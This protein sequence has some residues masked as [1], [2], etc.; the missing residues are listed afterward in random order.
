LALVQVS[1]KMHWLIPVERLLH[2]KS[3]DANQVDTQSQ[4]FLYKNTHIIQLLLMRALMK[5]K[6][7]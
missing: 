6:K 1:I 4:S 3:L 2:L 7:V 5:L